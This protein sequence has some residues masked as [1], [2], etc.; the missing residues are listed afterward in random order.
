[1]Q[2]QVLKKVQKRKPIFSNRG[3]YKMDVCVICGN[4]CR[5]G[6]CLSCS[7]DIEANDVIINKLKHTLASRKKMKNKELKE[8]D[9]WYNITEMQTNT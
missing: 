9:E 5:Y 1:M 3:R 4:P 2:K 8:D 6:I 7:D